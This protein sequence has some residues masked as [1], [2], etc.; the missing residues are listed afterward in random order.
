MWAQQ[1][2]FTA[3]QL[4]QITVRTAI[5]D[6]AHDEAIRREHT[7]YLAGIIPGARL[8]ILPDVSHFGMLQ[9]PQ[10]LSDA[11]IGFLK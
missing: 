11:V 2:N 3:A 5:V 1:P 6:G 8:I 7:E 4:K 10:E 9:S